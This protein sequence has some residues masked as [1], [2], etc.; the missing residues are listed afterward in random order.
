MGLR[1]ILFPTYQAADPTQPLDVDASLAPYYPEN[2]NFYFYGIQAAGRAEAMSVPTV[3]RAL[4]VIQTISSLPMVTRNEATGE[5]VSQP[6]VVN[7]PDPRIQ[8]SVFWAWI[9]SDLFFHPSAYGYVMDRYADTGRIRAMERVA[10][11]RV[12]ITTNANGTEIESY[13]IDGTYVD[14]NNLVVFAN[15]QEG[16]LAR[17]GRTIRAAAALEK[18][19]MNFA[20]EPMPQM[21][22]KSNGTSLPADRVAKLLSSWRTARANKS[23][24]FLNA[25]VTLE[26]LGFDPKSI[27]LN[28]A[29]N[30]VSLE[31]SRACG[32]PAYFT[33]SQ[34]SS[35]TY[36]NA[37]DKRRDLVDFAFRNYM[38]IIEE[39]MSFQDF[40]PQGNR[41]RFD[42]DDFLRGDPLARAQMYQILNGIGAMS[43]DEIRA[44]E[45][46]LL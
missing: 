2:Q 23:T 27:Q 44:E 20:V 9:I 38:T 22:L 35:F 37:L 46:L 33:D 36:S 17:A 42:L 31:L 5:K 40:T 21:V 3:S 29:R 28:E 15:T 26:T 4:G 10:P 24:A 25:D 7:Q 39:R 1:D 8:G 43:V 16:L 41:V 32:I 13:E 14:P 45:D 19:A 30:Y 11:E 6:R 18:A 34:Q 12:S